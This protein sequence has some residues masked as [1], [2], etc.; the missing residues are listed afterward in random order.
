[1]KAFEYARPADAAEAVGLVS[2]Q[3][4]AAY[5]AGGSNLV[6]HL[7]LGIARPDLLVDVRRLPLDEVVEHT[8]LA[9]RPRYVTARRVPES[10]RA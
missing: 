5:L 7:K 4:G 2:A 9:G 1:M 8:D 6:D 3:P 10:W